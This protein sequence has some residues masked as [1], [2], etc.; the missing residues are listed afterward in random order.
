M[1]TVLEVTSGAE[2]ERVLSANR[3]GAVVVD[4]WMMGCGPCNMIA[5]V[6]VELAR[7]FPTVRFVKIRGDLPANRVRG[8]C[9]AC[10]CACGLGV[11]CGLC[12]GAVCAVD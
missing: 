11:S 10:V 12:G 2:L 5:P 8:V 9:V 3:R 4:W 7:A 6:F 1:R